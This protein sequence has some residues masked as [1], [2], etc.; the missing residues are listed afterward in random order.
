MYKIGH[1]L[2][3]LLYNT[4]AINDLLKKGSKNQK[5]VLVMGLGIL[6]VIGYIS[7]YNVLTALNLVMMGQEA[8]IPAY[9]VAIVSLIILV[10]T[11]LGSN[12]IL[13]GT[14]DFEM[15]TALPIKSKDV[16]TSKFLFMYL[17]N[18]VMGILFM[19]PAGIVWLNTTKDNGLLFIMY[20]VATLFVPL[21]P[22]CIGVLIGIFIAILTSRCNNKNIFSLVFSLAFLVG[23][24]GVSIQSMS[25]GRDVGE[26]GVM[27]AAQINRL[28]P[29]AQLF[30]GGNQ[31]TYSM[32]SLFFIISLGVFWG[33]IEVIGRHYTQ[34]NDFITKNSSA[35]SRKVQNKQ[36]APL[37]AMYRKERARFL[38]SYLYMLN[39]GLGVF[40]LC[41]L[42]VVVAVISP[43]TL[44]EML[45]ASDC[46]ALVGQFGPLIIAATAAISCTTASAISLEGKNIWILQSIP[47]PQTT[48]INAKILLNMSVHGVGYIFAVGV[49]LFKFE[50]TV[51]QIIALIVVPLV[52]SAFIAVEGIYFNAKFPNFNWDNEMVVIKQSLPVIL[53]GL[54]GLAVV[55]IP[56]L[57][58]SLFSEVSPMILWG[59]AGILLAMT[60]WLYKKVCTMKI[61]V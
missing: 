17:L 6:L 24:T 13:F 57:L 46:T 32:N 51:T 8:L 4:F 25:N 18:V 38:G 35:S 26:I 41:I 55:I 52:Y 37:R 1:L 40:A 54:V 56:G 12:G 36:Y 11:F 21:I 7:A 44:A 2:K 5:Q 3:V 29:P 16:L 14:K 58:M 39:T 53:S 20:L 22:M 33:A 45:G 42:S 61:I 59:M 49:C 43:D 31:H 27:L 50:L 23:V 28:Y 34:I 48:F 15:L 9:M 30:I 10:F 60:Q 47:L 19:V